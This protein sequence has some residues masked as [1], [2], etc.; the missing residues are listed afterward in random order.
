MKEI[1]RQMK[2]VT[3]QMFG[4][5]KIT[6]E[7]LMVLPPRELDALVAKYIEGLPVVWG[8]DPYRVP[9]RRLTDHHA[10]LNGTVDG[11]HYDWEPVKRYSSDW[12][13][14]KRV[15]EAMSKH[16]LGLHLCTGIPPSNPPR[17]GLVY[18]VDFGPLNCLDWKGLPEHGMQGEDVPLVVVRAALW[19]I[20]ESAKSNL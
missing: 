3:K 12:N 11:R 2:S 18:Y 19:A 17:T 1:A 6:R 7:E 8:P 4:N 9:D 14:T 15:I 16:G 5:K 10:W 13:A 20:V